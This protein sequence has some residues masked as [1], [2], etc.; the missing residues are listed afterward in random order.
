MAAT[1]SSTGIKAAHPGSRTSRRL[2]KRPRARFPSQADPRHHHLLTT[3]EEGTV[4]VTR[5]SKDLT[6][7]RVAT[8]NPDHRTAATQDMDPSNS[9][10]TAGRVVILDPVHRL[11]DAVT[12]TI[13]RRRRH[14]VAS[15]SQHPDSGQ[16]EEAWVMVADS[17]VAGW[18]ALRRPPTSVSLRPECPNLF[19]LAA[20]P[21]PRP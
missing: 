2:A 1:A 20:I 8:L 16:G 5:S 17:A 9:S 18:A 19:L 21:M 12:Q 11:A 6:T 13:R 15:L 4:A 3:M 10:M 7:G 14:P